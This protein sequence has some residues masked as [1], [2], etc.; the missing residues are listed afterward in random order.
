M[1]TVFE[2]IKPKNYDWIRLH[3]YRMWQKTDILKIRT[4]LSIRLI[5]TDWGNLKLID[6]LYDLE[7]WYGE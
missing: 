5:E 6:N 2:D 3:L 4:D 1:T 7:R